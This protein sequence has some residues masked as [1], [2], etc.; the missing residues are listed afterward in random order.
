MIP[1]VASPAAESPSQRKTNHGIEQADRAFVYQPLQVTKTIRIIWLQPL[2]TKDTAS[3]VQIDL[4]EAFLDNCLSFEAV[5]YTWDGQQPDVQ[6]TCCGKALLVTKNCHSI[7]RGLRRREPR[8]LW[9][10]VIC[11]D[12]SSNEERNNQVRLMGDIY[13]KA[14]KV[15]IW[16]GE[17]DIKTRNLVFHLHLSLL[18]ETHAD[19]FKKLDQG[20]KSPSERSSYTVLRYLTL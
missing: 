11:I 10:D 12:Q 18:Y 13:R 4:D 16:P 7:L 8:A 9:I 5:S 2:A 19:T 14:D 3:D 20:M 17:C 6:I 15:L 1:T